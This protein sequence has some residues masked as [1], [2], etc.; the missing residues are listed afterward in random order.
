VHDD[1]ILDT[2]V[3]NRVLDEEGCCHPQQK[4]H[5]P[6]PRPLRRRWT[7][8][9]ITLTSPLLS[10]TTMKKSTETDRGLCL[11][12]LPMMSRGA[13]GASDAAGGDDN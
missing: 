3:T 8:T 1:T 7:G 10:T 6:F 2:I 11:R 9:A 13:R 12:L 4:D 5:A